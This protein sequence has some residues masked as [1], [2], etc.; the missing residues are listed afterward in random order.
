[1]FNEST[2]LVPGRFLVRSMSIVVAPSQSCPKI[3]LY[4]V[5]RCAHPRSL[6]PTLSA[7]SRGIGRSFLQGSRATRATTSFFGEIRRHQRRVTAMLTESGVRTPR[8]HCPFATPPLKIIPKAPLRGTLRG[9]GNCTASRRR[10]WS[11]A[12]PFR[13]TAAEPCPPAAEAD[14]LSGC[15]R[16]D[17][18]VI[19]LWDLKSGEELRRFKGHQKFVLAVTFS[20]DGRYALSGSSDQTL[21]LWRL[22]K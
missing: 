7:N 15:R 21:R 18:C 3:M 19:Q 9:A 17:H 6:L 5:R 2:Y 16:F 8:F 12:W 20:P 22:P 13:P 10:L 11:T 14:A 4:L 1:M